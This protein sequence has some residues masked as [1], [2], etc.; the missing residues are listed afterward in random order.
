MPRS[1]TPAATRRARIPIAA[2]TAATSDA[3]HVMTRVIAMMSNGIAMSTPKTNAP[4]LNSTS[5]PTALPSPVT[6]KRVK[7]PPA[8]VSADRGERH[9]LLLG[10]RCSR[11]RSPAEAGRGGAGQ[12][13]GGRDSGREWRYAKLLQRR[14][15]PPGHRHVDVHLGDLADLSRARQQRLVHL[16]GP[17]VR[18]R[19]RHQL[20]DLRSLGPTA[21]RLVVRRT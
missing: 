18:I 5:P 19:G 11:E 2:R 6:A 16:R 13:R 12:L 14:P 7:T 15:V 1:E 20:V 17:R 21:P 10:P 8:S 9:R 3:R 4:G